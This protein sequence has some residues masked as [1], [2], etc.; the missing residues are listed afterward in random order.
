MTWIK[1]PKNA[2]E[3]LLTGQD[4]LAD[5]IDA[6][7]RGA[8]RDGALA[9]QFKER[10]AN[11]AALA[12]LFRHPGR[13]GELISR[14]EAENCAFSRDLL[15]TDEGRDARSAFNS[16][17]RIALEIAELRD[18]FGKLPLGPETVVGETLV[19]VRF[20][21]DGLH[22]EEVQL[23]FSA[24][25]FASLA[26]ITLFDGASHFVS[27]GSGFR[28]ALCMLL[29]T[30]VSSFEETAN[31]IRIEFEGRVVMLSLNSAQVEPLIFYD[32]SGR[33]TVFE[34]ASP[35]R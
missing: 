20:S 12:M 17:R 8:A 4:K 13:I 1:A 27:G 24:G 10:L 15:A 23:G 14:L 7:L 29:G 6:L 11:A 25:C 21:G 33:A 26:R 28:D 16:L 5:Y 2:G 22:D 9:T 18:A 30:V 32:A 19:S 34:P 35:L 31:D 3:A